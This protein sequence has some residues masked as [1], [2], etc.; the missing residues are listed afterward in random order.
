MYPPCDHQ[1]IDT[2]V[3]VSGDVN[4][5]LEQDPEPIR[6]RRTPESILLRLFVT[7]DTNPDDT[8]AMR[9][10]LD[11]I[12]SIVPCT[13]AFFYEWRAQ[14]G[15]F[16]VTRE[17]STDVSLLKDYLTRARAIDPCAQ[18]KAR[19]QCIHSARSQTLA[20]RFAVDARIDTPFVKGFMARNDGLQH[21]L[22]HHADV[23]NGYFTSLHLF[24]SAGQTAFS[25]N[26]SNC[27][28]HL[29]AHIVLWLRQRWASTAL[30]QERDALQMAL[31][32]Q[33]T[34]VFLLDSHAKVLA[35]NHAANLQ[36][37]EGRRLSLTDNT[38][39]SG[40]QMDH[41][42]W[43]PEAIKRLMCPASNAESSQ[44]HLEPLPCSQT[45][46][47][48]H[49]G[50]L[51]RVAHNANAYANSNTNTATAMLT[52]IDTR[53][54]VARHAP[55]ELR[56]V[57]GFTGAEA[58]VADALVAGMGTDDIAEVFGIRRDTVR[59][60]IKRLLAKTGTRGNAELQKLLLRIAPNLLPLQRKNPHL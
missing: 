47:A 35:C 14:D 53:P 22:Y 12:T 25:Q 28:D 6:V 8:S 54:P 42:S 31:D 24:R 52:L 16:K 43:I 10:I 59:S 57:F 4:L 13:H 38:L 9:Q 46:H 32:V 20:D 15:Q 7:L 50:V 23:S 44:I 19:Q 11:A 27:L 48:R 55:S 45:R 60:H 29:H 30:R 39:L 56:R 34:P 26:E 3:A 1:F 41:A 58:K 37:R 21:V 5:S 40:S 18:D 49:Y 33:A 51:A 2:A 17:A 36:L